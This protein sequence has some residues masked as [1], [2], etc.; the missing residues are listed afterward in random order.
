[1]TGQTH[2]RI[3]A[4]LGAVIGGSTGDL[5]LALAGA[6]VGALCAKLPD[7][8]EGR[9]FEHRKTTHSVWALL[10]LAGLLALLETLPVWARLAV[11]VSYASHI[12]A[13]ACTV[14]GVYWLAPLNRTRKLRLTPQRVR[15]LTGGLLD[16]STGLIASV[17]LLWALWAVLPDYPLAAASYA[18]YADRISEGLMWVVSFESFVLRWCPFAGCS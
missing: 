12:L 18:P 15:V 7:Q 9:V 17:G 6:G 5:L 11:W 2:V 13:D 1:M 3:G 8:L 16:Q 10:L 4:A 14:S